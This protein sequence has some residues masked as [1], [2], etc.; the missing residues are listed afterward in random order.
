MTTTTADLYLNKALYNPPGVCRCG[1]GGKT[2][3]ANRNR[4]AQGWVKNEPTPYIPGHKPPRLGSDRHIVDPVTG[5][6]E[7]QGAKN[8]DG[9]GVVNSR[10]RGGFHTAHHAY[11]LRYRGLIPEGFVPDHKFCQNPGCVNP[12][13][14][15]LVTSAE[16]R[17]RAV[18]AKLTWEDVAH[19]R[20]KR[21]THHWK[22]IVEEYGITQPMVHRIWS[23]KSW[24]P[25]ESTPPEYEVVLRS[26]SPPQ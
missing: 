21:Q 22:Q 25:D 1:C 13:H 11:W 7:W 8:K 26:Y 20:G 3:I 24:T 14:L 4:W 5:C 17:R 18:S 12:E 16:N 9:Y 6:W 23:E 10:N 19:I 2:P 15:E